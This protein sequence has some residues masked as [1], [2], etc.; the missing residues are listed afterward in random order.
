M[1]R[2]MSFDQIVK[3]CESTLEMIR[4]LYD[5]ILAKEETEE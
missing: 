1:A 5:K 3:E 2:N 4:P